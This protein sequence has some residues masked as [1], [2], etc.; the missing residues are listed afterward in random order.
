MNPVITS[1]RNPLVKRIR[2]LRQKKQRLRERAFVVEGLRV[3]LTALELE[4]AVETLVWCPELLT[5]AVGQTA[6]QRAEAAGVPVAAVTPA[7]FAALSERD[8][9]V[10]LAAVVRIGSGPDDR[11]RV[12]PLAAL[13]PAAQAVYVALFDIGDPG[14]LGTIVRTADG[15]G[16]AGVILVGNTVDAFHPTAVKASMGALFNVTLA[17]ADSAPDLFAWARRHAVCTVATSAHAAVDYERAAWRFPA[18]LLM[19]SEGD[20]LPADVLDSAEMSVSIP[21][22]G[23]SS[24]LNLAVA[25]GLLLYRMVPAPP[26]ERPQ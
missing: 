19:G 25:T 18:L 13:A 23:V 24:S 11:P 22:R 9:P 26:S 14:N 16:A 3:V 6:V 15:A 10:G 1:T 8:N 7:V 20:G 21:M 4:A 12:V 17:A 5:S 2:L